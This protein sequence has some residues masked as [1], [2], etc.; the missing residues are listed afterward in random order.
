MTKQ[1]YCK[2]RVSAFGNRRLLF[3]L[4]FAKGGEFSLNKYGK[5]VKNIQ[6]KKE[7]LFACLL[8]DYKGFTASNSDPEMEEIASKRFCLNISQAD[9]SAKNT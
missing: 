7:K 2:S 9:R 4:G 3:S 5:N 1:A 6:Y 8:A